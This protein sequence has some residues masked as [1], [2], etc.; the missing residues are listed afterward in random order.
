ME[1]VRDIRIN[2]VL[3][4][5]NVSLERAINYLKDINIYIEQSPNTK[6]SVAVYE[7]LYK[8]FHLGIKPFSIRNLEIE[9]NTILIPS[10]T[11]NIVGWDHKRTFFVDENG[12]VLAL[13]LCLNTIT[14]ITNL[15]NFQKLKVLDLGHNKITDFSSLSELKEITDLVLNSTELKNIS[16][17]KDLKKLKNLS[18][19]QNRMNSYEVIS[20]LKNL[21]YL[22]VQSNDLNSISFLKNLSNLLELDISFNNLTDVSVLEGFNK[23]QKLIL[24]SNNVTDFDFLKRMKSLRALYIDFNH[25]SD[26]SFL[27]D[28]KIELL[29]IGENY[30]SDFSV[31]KTLKFLN[32]FRMEH[33]GLIDISFV[34]DIKNI[35]TLMLFGNRIEK[36]DA[37]KNL[38]NL[39][40]INIAQNFIKDI[41]EFNFIKDLPDLNII[42]YDNPCF[43][44]NNIILKKE[45]NNYDVILNECKK[46]ED[47]QVDGRIPEKIL[48][49]GNHSSGK[50]TLL[51]YLQNEIL[52]PN[53]DSTHILKIEN[54]P[55]KYE[56]LPKAIIYDFGGQDFYHG[57]YNAFMTVNSI[58]LLLWD[59]NTNRNYI[60]LDKKSRQ[61]INYDV[62]YWMGQ[63]VKNNYSGEIFL[64][65]SHSDEIGS[66]RKSYCN[67]YDL[68]GE[69]YISLKE[70]EGVNTY[71]K[72]T[73]DKT[74]EYLKFN[75]D[76]L[77]EEKQ[78]NKNQKGLIS[79]QVFKLINYILNSKKSHLP[80]EKD[81]LKKYYSVNDDERFNTEIEQLHL[82][83]MILVHNENVWLK[84]VV[85]AEYF[86][87]IILGEN[88][89]GNGIIEKKKFDKIIDVRI[90]DLLIDQKVIFLHKNKI[91]KEANS[92]E[93]YIIPNYLPLTSD[94]KVDYSLITFGFGDPLFI[95]KFNDY[96]PFGF[97]N[98]MICRLGN[99]SD[100]KK[101]WRDQLVFNISFN[102]RKENNDIKVLTF[103]VL[104]K[105]DYSEL[106][107]K[108][109]VLFEKDTSEA[110]KIAI[111]KHLFRA[112][113][114]L[115]NFNIKI[116]NFIENLRQ[117]F[118]NVVP[119]NLY[120]S[121]NNHNYIHFKDLKEFDINETKIRTY[122]FNSLGEK[123]NE[124]EIAVSKFQN[125][126]TKNLK[127]MK[128]VFISYSNED[129]YYKDLLIKNLKP[130]TQFQLLKPW[131]CEDMTS[132][133]W[134][135]QIQNELKESEIVI[136]MMSLNFITSDYI[137]REEV[138]KTFEE[139]KNNPNKK[140]ICVLVKNFAWQYFDKFKKLTNLTDEDFVALQDANTLNELTSKQFVPYDIE[141]KGTQQE[142]R[143]LKPL[144]KWEYEEDAY[145]E[146]V[147]NIVENL[148]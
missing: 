11:I 59:Q 36:L 132:G 15:K 148:S 119:E 1:E 86:H 83:G 92:V 54:Y 22:S 66:K 80:V 4:E 33:S 60:D 5:L 94:S 9:L 3:R 129:H 124:K 73:N 123:F 72:K 71:V 147:R 93:E 114:K 43:A 143:F 32:N 116:D 146:I 25:L 74:L 44:E 23:I 16:F 145:V 113:I 37:L 12:E 100:S 27:K 131:S 130:L 109:Y 62:N 91:L 90:K 85:L 21:Q 112:I 125:F 69:F 135:D 65:Q 128:K 57:I 78:Y 89:I 50:S 64:I 20:E 34:K 82:Q 51:N 97:I 106:K 107:V 63:R 108:T 26:I 2:K 68:D 120:L 136:F 99:L 61:N 30:I 95:L 142:R 53:T 46:L 49:L 76:S 111:E 18:I 88:L 118:D 126:T 31:L 122:S 52:Y 133:N 102:S 48:L 96:I 6:I 105:L 67:E 39:K 87:S 55:L 8:K 110:Y 28:L 104:I 81:S 29:S 117:S 141:H 137:L 84:P 75:L 7:L 58:T 127:S 47:E 10:N 38:K 70:S 77:I 17:L 41:S 19:A 98:Q 121:K 40:N 56:K 35:Q 14:D 115:Y 139:I 103:K 45:T 138:F 42:A 24:S 13:N 140:V 79:K 134:H 144:N 101:I